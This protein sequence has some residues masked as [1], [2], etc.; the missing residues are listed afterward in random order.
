MVEPLEGCFHRTNYSVL[1]GLQADMLLGTL[2]G[3]QFRLGPTGAI[4]FAD[5][6]REQ[7]FQDWYLIQNGTPHS[8]PC[9]LRA[10]W[11]RDTGLPPV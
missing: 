2:E 3:P 7:H 11:R 5:E 9:E 1:V 6:E 10:E 4:V 8:E